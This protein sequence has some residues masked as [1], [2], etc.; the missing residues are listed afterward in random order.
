[1]ILTARIR[2]SFI[3]AL[4]FDRDG[5]SEAKRKVRRSSLTEWND[6]ANDSKI[7]LRAQAIRSGQTNIIKR[8]ISME[9]LILAQDERWRQA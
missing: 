8:L 5:D 1:M 3:F 2:K 7:N 9:S 4:T 6:V